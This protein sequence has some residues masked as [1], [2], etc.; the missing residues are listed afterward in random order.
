MAGLWNSFCL[1]C[2]LLDDVKWFYLPQK[3]LGFLTSAGVFLGWPW[4]LPIQ[5]LPTYSKVANLWHWSYWEEEGKCNL[6]SVYCVPGTPL[7][8]PTVS[9]QSAGHLTSYWK[10]YSQP[11]DYL[12]ILFLRGCISH[13]L[14]QNKLPHTLQLITTHIYYI[15]ISVGQD[16][17][18]SLTEFSAWGLTR[19]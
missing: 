5:S 12:S 7:Q 11:C 14:L 16:S 13:L 19:L 4:K 6:L 1:V 2:S 10:P 17:G 18:H 9:Q 8:Y 15:T 3:K